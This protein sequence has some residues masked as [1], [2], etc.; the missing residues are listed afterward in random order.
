MHL[1][2]EKI[3]QKEKNI[4]VL[5]KAYGED[6][7]EELLKKEEITVTELKVARDIIKQK[8]KNE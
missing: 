3:K 6:K 5:V 7:R 4:E 8:E 2:Y 1:D